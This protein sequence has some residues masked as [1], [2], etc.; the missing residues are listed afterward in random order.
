MRYLFDTNVII[1][2]LTERH[3]DYKCSQFL[4]KR[5]ASKEIAGY[6]CSKQVTDIYYI[7]RKYYGEKERRQL[8]KMIC[9]TFEIV[10]LLNSYLSYCLK[11]EIVDYEDAIIDEAAKVNMIDAIVTNDIK[12]FANSTRVIFSP[13]DLYTLL[14]VV[15]N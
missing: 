13:K 3:P 9:E 15:N 8:I 1:D 6:I 12:D 2:A 5:V 10:P 14:N 4:L 7:L 11:S